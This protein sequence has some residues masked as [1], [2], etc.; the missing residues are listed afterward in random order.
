MLAATKTTCG[1]RACRMRAAT[2]SFTLPPGLANSTLAS[3]CASERPQLQRSCGDTLQPSS[4]SQP[5]ASDRL[6]MRTSGVLPMAPSTPSP[7]PAMRA[8]RERR[9]EQARLR[10]ARHVRG[11]AGTLRV[12]RAAYSHQVR[13]DSHSAVQAAAAAAAD[14]SSARVEEELSTAD[15]AGGRSHFCRGG[16]ACSAA[17]MARRRFSGA[18][19]GCS[20]S[21]GTRAEETQLGV[22]ST[23][24]HESQRERFS[25][26]ARGVLRVLCLLFCAAH[27][28]L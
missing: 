2:R 27:C 18:Q 16:G 8:K 21:C 3:I 19:L 7:P 20:T 6:L 17:H 5:V 15:M 13:C 26:P 14:S 24:S 4:T 12:C 28:A 11:S 25:L 9:A 1:T 23:L 10:G 22:S